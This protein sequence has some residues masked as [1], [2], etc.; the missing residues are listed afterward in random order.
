MVEIA[1][2]DVDRDTHTSNRGGGVQPQRRDEQD[3]AGSEDRFMRG[4]VGN[5]HNVAVS[6]AVEDVEAGA[7]GARGNLQ[8][9]DIGG[10][11]ENQPLLATN[12]A[13]DV[14]HNLADC[15]LLC[16]TCVR[17]LGQSKHMLTS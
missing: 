14:G 5:G 7:G 9:L 15:Q 16:G 4:G 8:V 11:V 2:E 3:L 1:E 12:L 6:D 17:R 10:R 13:E